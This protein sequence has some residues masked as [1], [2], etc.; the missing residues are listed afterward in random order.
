MSLK[1]TRKFWIFVSLLGFF[2]DAAAHE[3]APKATISCQVSQVF[4]GKIQKKTLLQ[5]VLFKNMGSVRAFFVKVY[6]KEATSEPISL[7]SFYIKEDSNERF[8]FFFQRYETVPRFG[9]RQLILEILR[10][11]GKGVLLYKRTWYERPWTYHLKN[12]HFKA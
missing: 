10:P 5:S 9:K 11:E 2:Q 1:K 7:A 8:Y 3:K 6:P 4:E 12:C